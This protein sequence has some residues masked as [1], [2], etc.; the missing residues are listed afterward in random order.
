MAAT[1]LGDQGA[2][3]IKVESPG[4]DEYR[5][6]GTRRGGFSASFMAANRNKRSITLDLK[7]PSHAA[8]LRKL[9]SVADVFIQNQRPGVVERLGFGAAQICA[10]LPRLIYVSISGYGRTGPKSGERAFDTMV[11]AMVGM[12][13][14]Q[15]DADGRPHMMRTLLVDKTTSPIV[16]QAICAALF[17]RGQTG[18]GCNIDYS[19]LDAMVW[20]M[21]PDGMIN[22]TF[23]GGGVEPGIAVA[24]ADFVCKTA[25]GYMVVSPH[26]ESAWHHFTKLIG[27]PELYLDP[28]F[29]PVSERMRNL[30]EYSYV[31]RTSLSSRTTDEW[32]RLFAENDIPYAPVLTVGEV[33]KHPQ[34]VWNG[35]VEEVDHPTAGKYR[36]PKGPVFFNNQRNG[37]WRQVPQA[38]EHSAEIMAEF[39]IML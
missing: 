37:T 10:E 23:I 18:K 35:I 2:D 20:W 6:G 7:Q 3:V 12:A 27:K 25:D 36:S 29:S 39:G 14:V 5:R 19:M 17:Q 33:A 26:Q 22:D 4:G 30:K 32:C 8:A 13:S 16:A 1:I 38:G 28:R 21:W 34:V 9:I 31:V 11:Q 24:D 15:R